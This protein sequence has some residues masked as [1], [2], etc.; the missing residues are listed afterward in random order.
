MLTSNTVS[1]RQKAAALIAMSMF[2][3][4]G[5]T[6]NGTA[7]RADRNTISDKVLTLPDSASASPK[8]GQ[9]RPHWSTG[10]LKLPAEMLSRRG[11]INAQRSPD[12]GYDFL[13]AL[14]KFAVHNKAQFQL[15]SESDFPEVTVDSIRT[16]I[17]AGIPD[18]GSR[19]ILRMIE[20]QI[21]YK[22]IPVLDG[23]FL[24]V[25]SDATLHGIRGEILPRMV[26]SQRFDSI[27]FAA[28]LRK[29]QVDRILRDRLVG[30]AAAVKIIFPPT[31]LV[32]DFSARRA[33]FIAW[34]E[35]TRYKID[36]LTGEI[37]SEQSFQMVPGWERY[38]FTT[39]TALSVDEYDPIGLW[40]NP[41]V[42]ASKLADYEG[43]LLDRKVTDWVVLTTGR[44]PMA[45]Q[46]RL[47]Y[48]AGDGT[49]S[50]FPFPTVHPGDTFSETA[51]KEAGCFSDSLV[52]RPAVGD[53]V[54][55]LRP[56]AYQNAYL[57]AMSAARNALWDLPTAIY[58][59]FLP[60]NQ[61]K[62]HIKVVAPGADEPLYR[63]S[64][65]TIRIT[66]NA[67]HGRLVLHEYGHYV[68]DTYKPENYLQDSCLTRS[69]SEG[70]ADALRESLRWVIRKNVASDV[71][72][73]EDAG[74][75]TKDKIRKAISSES[76]CS[77]NDYGDGA[78][79]SQ[80]LW[81]FL[82]DRVCN[83]DQA[84]GASAP[85]QIN[86]ILGD[87]RLGAAPID[88]WGRESLTQ[89]MYYSGRWASADSPSSPYKFVN[90]M[91]YWF[92]VLSE[93]YGLIHQDE[94][95]RIRMV[96][97]LHGVNIGPFQP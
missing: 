57:Y 68:H 63:W 27:N 39:L 3:V 53:N 77:G 47:T 48:G 59:W 36:A 91:G 96:F 21:Y 55:S 75:Q 78:A 40:H 89:A 82:N 37:Y 26:L 49:E 90:D 28:L 12:G 80:I 14:K 66:D 1:N 11:L 8:G 23:S 44:V 62:L 30:P 92:K 65:H 76:E 35:G 10:R 6:V 5:C 51:T 29:E 86:R 25:F 9:S 4:G 13:G 72:F 87:A 33:A 31:K 73:F 79:I 88:Q 74:T 67:L 60:R 17:P 16:V 15:Q 54:E 94:W 69:V 84:Q 20:C 71:V 2:L 19:P 46:F 41:A 64:T 97:M 22:D 42:I 95:D 24:A 38:D 93:V 52:M 34:H 32:L 50:I 7:L 70:V 81:A 45:C 83:F 43:S 58:A 61:Y 56:L 85:C 18:S